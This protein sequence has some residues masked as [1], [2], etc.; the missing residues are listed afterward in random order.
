MSSKQG[1]KRKAANNL[2]EVIDL[3]EDSDTEDAGTEPLS[4]DTRREVINLVDVDGNDEPEPPV[5]LSS[6]IGAKMSETILP[7]WKVVLLVDVS[8][9][10]VFFNQLNQVGV[11]CERRRLVTFDFLWVARRC[12]I[13]SCEDRVEYVL[14]HACER[15]EIVDLVNSLNAKNKSTGLARTAYQKLKMDNS[16]VE[17][18]FYIVQGAIKDL[19]KTHMQCDLGM[20]KRVHLYTKTMEEDGYTVQRF[21]QDGATQIV[22]FLRGIHK[23]V[24]SQVANKQPPDTYMTLKAMS[25]RADWVTELGSARKLLPVGVMGE[26]KLQMILSEFPVGFK[27]EYDSDSAAVVQRLASLKTDK[28]RGISQSTAQSLCSNLFGVSAGPPRTEH[29]AGPPRM[30][31]APVTPETYPS[32]RGHRRRL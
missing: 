27:A 6:K 23:H 18:K 24:E 9:P 30:E 11:L 15:K 29:S 17:N 21:A 12:T 32:A 1:A 5:A 22:D 14:G 13:A 26:K 19:Y 25:E 31:H 4:V 3:V 8:E 10:V 2:S 20:A 16:G 7:S 28:G